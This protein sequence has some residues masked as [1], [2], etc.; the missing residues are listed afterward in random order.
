MKKINKLFD[1]KS[2]SEIVLY[3]LVFII[4]CAFAFSYLY[5]IFWCAYSGM[6]DFRSLAKDP[7]GFSKVQLKNYID[8]F[9]LLETD[10]TVAA[11]PATTERINAKINAFLNI[12][13]SLTPTKYFL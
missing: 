9:K 8:V 5:M 6:R 3:M 11:K 7:F 13:I 12:F 4:F 2:P 1:R 10:G